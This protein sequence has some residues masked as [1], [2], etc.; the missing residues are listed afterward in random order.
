M[1]RLIA[2]FVALPA[3]AMAT[4]NVNTAQQ[5]DLQKAKGLDRYKAKAII[6]W[7]NQNGAIDNFAELEQV[8]G[9]TPE[10][11]EKAKAGLAF[12]G[13]PFVPSPKAKPQKK[14]K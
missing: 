12:S 11:I 3:I 14:R 13:D 6:D 9:F 1:K 4:V 2:L 8:P 10:V 7:R 5:S